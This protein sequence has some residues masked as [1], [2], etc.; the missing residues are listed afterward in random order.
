MRPIHPPVAVNSSQESSL[1]E[2]VIDPGQPL[3]GVGTFSRSRGEERRLD[4][5]SGGVHRRFQRK[6]S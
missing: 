6:P 5:I 4:V 1:S 3:Y 2:S